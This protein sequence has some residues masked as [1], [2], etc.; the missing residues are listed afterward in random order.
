MN[1]V[2]PGLEPVGDVV[3]RSVPRLESAEKVTGR[4]QYTDDLY[5]PGMLYGAVL[6]SPC[7][8]ARILG[9]DTSAARALPGVKAVLTAADFPA[10]RTGGFVHDQLPLA[11][12]KAL[13]IGD[14][15]AVVAATDLATARAATLLIEVEFEEL[16]PVLDAVAALAPDAPLVHD[17]RANYTALYELPEHPNAVSHTGF[18]EGDVEAAWAQCD[19]IVEGEYEVPAQSHVYLEPCAALAEVDGTGK[20]TVWS[21][22]QGVAR[23]QV[24]IAHA[25][26]LPMAKIRC[27]APR[28]GGGFG[29]KGEVSNQSLCA[30]LA[31]ATGRPVK[32]VMTRDEDMTTVRRRHS[33]RVR[34][35]TGARRDG[36]LVARWAE[37]ILDGG[38]YAE[39]SPGVASFSAYFARGPY[40]IPHVHVDAWAVYTN[41]LRASAFRG[42]GNPQISFPAEQQ[43][44]ELAAK[45]GMDP[46]DLRLKNAIEGGEPWLGGQRVEVGQV[47]ACLERV[48]AASDWDRRRGDCAARARRGWRRGVGVA[49]VAHT[50]AFLSAGATVRLNQDGSVTVSTGAQDIGEGADT[51]LAQIAAG[52]LGLALDQVNYVNPDTDVSPYNFLTAGSRI[53]YTVGSA[54][55]QSCERVR[56][57]LFRDASEMF[58]CSEEDIELRPGGFV[59]IKGQPDATLPFAAI[60]ERALFAG[61]GPISGSHDWRFPS[62]PFDPKRAIVL[63]FDLPGTLGIF[64]FGA[65]VFEV[66]VDEAT[67]RVEVLEVWA[68]HDVGRAINPMLVEGQ[69]QGGI[70]QGMGYALMEELVWEDGRL[71]NPTLMDYK[72]PGMADVPAAIHALILETPEAT[73]PFGARGIG[74][75]GLVAPAPAIA[76]AILHA[77]GASVRRLPITPERMF[78]ALD[79]R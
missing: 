15:I 31:V 48:R 44:D 4:A 54:V 42:F 18:R 1:A 46:I 53:T 52:S 7:T 22:M 79:R 74:E 6:G 60:A 13:Y 17:D 67:G 77:T 69:I 70:V 3:G 8:H 49:A 37:V 47:R 11:R 12:D 16:A 32:M 65:Q 25:L 55:R 45:L 5:R 57:R 24:E 23:V 51:A 41:T 68:A 40:R 58:E 21:S 56:E 26:G 75:I 38:A 27:I 19:V 71:V 10:T 62:Q 30:A 33:G 28:V 73:A 59:G 63:G 50:S 61:G 66:E 9:I 39:E 34:I 76:N 36:T 72:I 64:A 20:V 43:L 14:P 35:K 2:L 29:G 78:A